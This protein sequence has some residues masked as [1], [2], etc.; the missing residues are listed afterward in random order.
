L[1]GQVPHFLLAISG[2]NQD[3]ADVVAGAE[4]LDEGAAILARRVLEAEEAGVGIVHEEK[5]LQ[6]GRRRWKD[7]LPSAELGP[8]G[9]P[10]GSLSHS[11][12][13]SLS[14]TL[15]DFRHGF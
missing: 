6:A 9:D 13:E 15:A 7:R 4:M 3:A 2:N 11:A 10:H 5:A 14:G 1:L 8:A 12:A